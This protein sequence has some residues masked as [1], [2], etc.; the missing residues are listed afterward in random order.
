MK[1]KKKKKRKKK[2]EKEEEERRRRRE[3]KKEEEEEEEERR[4]RRERRRRGEEKKEEEEKEE[5]RREKK[6]KKRGEE[7]GRRRRRRRKK[8]EDEVMQR[9]LSSESRERCSDTTWKSVPPQGS[10]TKSK[11]GIQNSETGQRIDNNMMKTPKVVPPS[12]EGKGENVEDFFEEYNLAAELNNWTEEVKVKFLPYY[13]KGSAKVLFQNEKDN[14]NNWAAVEELFKNNYSSMGV[15]QALQLD[16]YHRGQEPHES[17]TDYIQMKVKLIQKV[18]PQ[19]PEVEK[20]NLILFGLMPEIAARVASMPGNNTVQGLKDNIK[21]TEFSNF[22]TER[23]IQRVRKTS[24]GAL[25]VGN[26]D[27]NPAKW[28][29]EL[30]KAI[31]N[32]K[33][34]ETEQAGYNPPRGHRVSAE[35][36]RTSQDKITSV[37]EY[38][39]PK[40]VKQVRQFLGLTGYYRK[41]CKDYAK[42]AAPLT[43]LTK[44]DKPFQW[45]EIEQVAFDRLKENLINTPTLRHFDEELPII[46]EVD[47]SGIGLGCI[48]SQKEGKTIRPVAYG[49]R[50]LSEVEQK[51][52]NVE[53]E[54]L[55]CVYAVNLWRHYLYMKDFELRTD[56]HSLIYYK[57]LKDPSSRLIRF[58]LKLQEYSGMKI[59]Y[60]PGRKN[61]APDAL[62][63]APVDPPEKGEDDEEI[64]VLSIQDINLPELQRDD[65]E[66]SRIF[67]SLEHPHSV[68]IQEERQSRR[69]RI[70]DDILY[71]KGNGDVPDL[72]MVPKVLIEVIIDQYHKQRLGGGHVGVR[73]VVEAISN[74]YYWT[75]NDYSIIKDRKNRRKTARTSHIPNGAAPRV[76]VPEANASVE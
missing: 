62:S 76:I 37:V 40:T 55:A 41:F 56:C 59:V 70:K 33:I 17:V 8:K 42:I 25:T 69:Y 60:Q 66:L 31:S 27:S 57:N 12:F 63:R 44:K 15:Q 58:A 26:N 13:L 6:K 9:A 52:A 19:M 65:E 5:G 21:L 71:K 43:E 39:P 24:V 74:K 68:S 35:G 2:K 48:L 11:R 50:K 18:N 64:P 46:V 16:M 36:V 23:A 34:N 32:I 30:V 47:A 29:E 49:S 3:K 51:Y 22:V 75:T 67:M 61:M 20:A 53:R 1:K 72:V 4:R 10:H 45:T 14:M 73:K 7:E 28:A 54:F 38:K